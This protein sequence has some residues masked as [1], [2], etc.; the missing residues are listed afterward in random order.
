MIL[1]NKK[2]KKKRQLRTDQL[3][4][5]Q[6]LQVCLYITIYNIP[7]L[8]NMKLKQSKNLWIQ[9]LIVCYFQ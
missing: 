4:M 6:K 9:Y 1:Q 2:D 3:N 5:R 8:L 7:N